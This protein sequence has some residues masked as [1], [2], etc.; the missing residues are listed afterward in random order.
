MRI[1]SLTLIISSNQKQELTSMLSL[2]SLS[3]VN[4]GTCCC[5]IFPIH[6]TKLCVYI[7]KKENV[8]ILFSAS[9][10][11]FITGGVRWR[12][13]G[14]FISSAFAHLSGVGCPEAG[15]PCRTGKGTVAGWNVLAAGHTLPQSWSVFCCLYLQENNQNWYELRNLQSLLIHSTLDFPDFFLPDFLFT[16]QWTGGRKISNHLHS[17]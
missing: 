10:C 6:N 17:Q 2:S 4:S 5:S 11:R 9:H 8:F 12:K 16:R 7:K 14:I 3:L 15:Y 1:L 13:L